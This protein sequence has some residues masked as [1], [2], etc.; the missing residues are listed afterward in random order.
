MIL[1]AAGP[2]SHLLVLEL[3]PPGPSHFAPPVLKLR[4]SHLTVLML[5][6]SRQSHSRT[7]ALCTYRC[8]SSG[9]WAHRTLHLS[10]LKLRFSRTVAFHRNV[11]LWRLPDDPAFRHTHD[12][13]RH[14]PAPL[15]PGEP[16]PRRA[17]GLF[18]PRSPLEDDDAPLLV[19]ALVG[20]RRA[21]R[22]LVAMPAYNEEA[23]IAKT[24]LGARRHADAVLVV[25]DGSTDD[26]VAIAEA[27]GAIVVRHT[28]NKGYGGALQTIFS[29]ARGMGVEELVI[30][31]A[32]GQ[33]D[34]GDI[35]RL[36]SE[37][38]PGR[39]RSSRPPGRRARLAPTGDGRSRR[40]TRA[41]S[42]PAQIS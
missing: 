34:P 4:F 18:S 27:L 12:A 29:T 23:Y 24:V 38:G 9:P 3:R 2:R 32:D 17:G 39:M 37:S 1:E 6:P 36:L 15:P 10:V 25:D 16:L 21:V 14:P 30:I 13:A 20:V 11:A 40:S 19:D 42:P 5:L 22:T 33:H 35:P 8:S 26:T 41:T 31:D 7:V 28:T